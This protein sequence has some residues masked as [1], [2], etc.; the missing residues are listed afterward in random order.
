MDLAF[1]K[2]VLEGA[3]Y[4]IK[5][6]EVAHVNNNYVRAGEIVPIELVAFTDITEEVD[7]LIEGTKARIEKAIRVA[8]ANDM[9]DPSPEQAKLKSYNDWLG[10]RKKYPPLPDNSI[11]FLPNMDAEKSSKLMKD[12]IATVDE[13]KDFTFSSH[14]RKSI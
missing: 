1:Q 3:G 11:H 4:P 13:I 2:V 10:V 5:R 9:P 7:G 8:Q 12:G 14:Q 6:C